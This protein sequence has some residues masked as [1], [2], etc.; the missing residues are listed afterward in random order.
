MS[1][2]CLIVVLLL[3]VFLTKPHDAWS[4]P[5]DQASA[6]N[7]V[8]DRLTELLKIDSLVTDFKQQSLD[9]RGVLLRQSTGRLWLSRPNL[10]RIETDPPFAQTMVSNG[11]K[12]WIYDPDLEQVTVRSL[13]SL[14]EIPIL[15]LT[16]SAEVL[17][18]RF[19]ID[20]REEQGP[21]YFV[22]TPKSQESL[23]RVLSLGFAD[24]RPSFM[25]LEDSLGQNTAFEF[26]SPI[27]DSEIDREIFT[28]DVPEHVDVLHN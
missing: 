2:R 25:R 14:G 28:F 10:F 20:Y 6:R 8:K 22:L 11:D 17:H 4:A 16:S 3:T 1:A 23:L 19:R 15:L 7:E 24:D 9:E 27:L 13:Q 12:L 26:T 5:D 21:G 18:E